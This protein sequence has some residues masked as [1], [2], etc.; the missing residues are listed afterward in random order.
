[1]SLDFYNKVG[2]K[3]KGYEIIVV[4]LLKYIFDVSMS[5][6]QFPNQERKW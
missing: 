6:Q 2:F 3:I 5:Q 1:M 4:S